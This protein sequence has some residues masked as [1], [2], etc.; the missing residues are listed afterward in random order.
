MLNTPIYGGITS[1]FHL[2]SVCP[3]TFSGLSDEKLDEALLHVERDVEDSVRKDLCHAATYFESESFEQY[4][5]RFQ[6]LAEQANELVW[7]AAC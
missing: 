5:E 1:C 3:C 7:S 4:A 2:P 6:T